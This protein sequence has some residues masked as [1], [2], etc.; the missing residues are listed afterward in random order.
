MKLKRVLIPIYN[1]YLTII[2]TKKFNKVAKMYDVEDSKYAEAIVQT[3]ERKGVRE[4]IYIQHKKIEV[5]Q[6][7]HEA[8]H[9]VN[10]IF[11]DRGQILDPLNDEA[12]C[13][14]LG[15]IVGLIHKH[16]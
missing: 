15:F 14:L 1:C 11:N 7:A 8:K 10:R 6:I 16:T 3:R 5:D 13:Y 4:Y 12:E 9:I 2:V